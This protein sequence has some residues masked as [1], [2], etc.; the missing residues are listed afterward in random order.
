MGSP[1]GN[2]GT[3]TAYTWAANGGCTSLPAPESW[4]GSDLYGQTAFADPNTASY[5]VTYGD[6]QTRSVTTGES[7][8]PPG[9]LS[10][11]SWCKAQNHS[12]NNAVY[13]CNSRYAVLPDGSRLDD[14]ANL[15][16]ANMFVGE[17]DSATWIADSFTNIA[18]RTAIP[19]YWWQNDGHGGFRSCNVEVPTDTASARVTYTITARG[20][21][22]WEEYSRPGEFGDAMCSTPTRTAIAFDPNL[23]GVYVADQGLDSIS[24]VLASGNVVHDPFQASPISYPSALPLYPSAQA[25]AVNPTTHK[26]Y[27]GDEGSPWYQTDPITGQVTSTTPGGARVVDLQTNRVR[28]VIN[29][30]RPSYTSLHNLTAIAVNSVTNRAYVVNNL[31][32]TVTIIDGIA[33]TVLG[34]ISVGSGATSWMGVAVDQVLN[35]IFVTNYNTNTLYEIDGNTNTIQKSIALGVGPGGVAVDPA[36]HTVYVTDINGGGVLVVNPVTGQFIEIP[37]VGASPIAIGVLPDPNPL[38]PSRL[39][40][41]STGITGKLNGVVVSPAG[42]GPGHH[43]QCREQCRHRLRP[44]LLRRPRP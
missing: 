30:G 29:L 43:H 2:S 7:T 21:Y 5:T 36:T 31:L 39:Y 38:N 32:D 26:L 8:I 11:A 1:I 37:Q 4:Y 13:A 33:D 18:S 34:S 16:R 28:A 15:A 42:P 25:L 9:A 35:R 44:E 6:G 3:L 24:A 40:V 17:L 12:F 41:A 10:P 20:D 19:Q 22:Q 23:G 27:V 14:P